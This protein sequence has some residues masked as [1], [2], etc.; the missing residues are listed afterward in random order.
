VIAVEDLRVALGGTDV[1]A[2]VSLSVERGEFV[3]LV[4][5]NGAGKT[6]L[7]RAINGALDPDAGSVTVDG[8]PVAER[9]ADA[10]GRRV[11]TVPQRSAV[12]FGFTVE[13]VVEMGRA[14]HRS[15]LDWTDGGEAVEAAMERTAVARLRDRRVDDLSGGERQRVL[16]AR[17]LAQEA[18]VL[19]LDEP[20]ANLDINHQVRV[21]GLVADLVAEGRTALAAIHDLDLAARYC[22]R[23]CLLHDGR[24][25]AAGP[26]EEVLDAAGLAEAFEAETA[27]AEHPVTGAPTVTAFEERPEGGPLVHVVGGGAPGARAVGALRRAGCRVTLGPIPEG[28][29]AARAATALD[30]AAVTTEPFASPDGVRERARSLARAADVLVDSGGP[31]AARARA[32]IGEHPRTVEADRVDDL[33]RAVLGDGR[34]VAAD[35]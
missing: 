19:L 26:P 7:L 25:R 10:L 9:S 12:G 24:I 15:R 23:L 32:V 18:P 4:G 34:A 22:D 13:G 35:D 17:A 1:L 3:G 33:A 21:L 16:L 8:A 28:D 6:T 31:G 27:V 5:P 11:A 29:A 14:P 2:G 20:T 30:C